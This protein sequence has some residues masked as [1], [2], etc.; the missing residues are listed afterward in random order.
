M[1][2]EQDWADLRTRYEEEPGGGVAPGRVP[3][4]RYRADYGVGGKGPTFFRYQSTGGFVSLTDS[5]AIVIEF[6]GI[7]AEVEIFVLDNPAVIGFLDKLQERVDDIQISANNFYNPQLRCAKVRARNA[8]VG[9]T[10]RIQIV[11]KW[12]EELSDEEHYGR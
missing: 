5:D 11:G 2:T 7:P 6:E 4:A 1:L 8:T 10:S 3:S 12:A 9:S